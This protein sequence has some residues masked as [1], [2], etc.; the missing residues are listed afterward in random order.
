MNKRDNPM[1]LVLT[2]VVTFGVSVVGIWWAYQFGF[3][4]NSVAENKSVTE[5]TYTSKP[6]PVNKLP[7][8]SKLTDV[9]TPIIKKLKTADDIQKSQVQELI[10][11][12]IDSTQ[13]P[14]DGVQKLNKLAQ[15]I[16]Q[17][18]PQTVG[19]RVISIFGN[20]E[21]SQDFSHQRGEEV[22]GYLR[23]RG[24]KH[25]IVISH[26]GAK[27]SP[28]HFSPQDESNPPVKIQLYGLP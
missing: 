2:L 11:F 3:G 19:I 7:N 22:A 5:T 21:S 16:A 9:P 4:L 20:A 23:D 1:V 27:S 10:E 6:E 12:P 26:K 13:I 25:K 24:L 15:K 8:Q 17:F 14:E 18:N 28:N